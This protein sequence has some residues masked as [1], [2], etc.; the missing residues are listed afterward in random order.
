MSGS[1]RLIR[2]TLLWLAPTALV[3]A[4][5]T[6]YYNVF[7]RHATENLLHLVESPDASDLLPTSRH[8]MAVTRTDLPPSRGS[9]RDIRITDTH[10]NLVLL[11]ALFLGIPGVA[12]RERFGN[13]GWAVLLSVFFH[14]LSL[15]F[16]VEFVYATQL[17]EWSASHYSTAGQIFWGLGKHLLDLPFKFAWPLLLWSAFYFERLRPAAVERPKP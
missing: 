4:L 2:G 12:W 5:L 8:E 11:G 10:F 14:L 7:L 15:V 16:Y 17:G 9:L 13:F 6:P 3:W 1:G